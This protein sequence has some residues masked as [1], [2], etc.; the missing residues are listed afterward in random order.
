[1]ITNETTGATFSA[2]PFPP[3]IKDIIE[4]GGLVARTKA[5]V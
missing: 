5:R 1:V 3:F 2:Q 4:S